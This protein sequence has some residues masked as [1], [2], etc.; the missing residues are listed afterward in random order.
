[1]I[2]QTLVTMTLA[3]LLA[4]CTSP[5]TESGPRPNV[6]IVVLDACRADK[7]SLYGF[8]RETTPNLSSLASDPDAVVFRRHYVQAPW[9]KPSTASLFTGRYVSQHKVYRG[10]GPRDNKTAQGAYVTDRLQDFQDVMAER[11]QRAGYRTFAVVWGGQVLPEYG[12]GQGFDQFFTDDVRGRV[13]QVRKILEVLDG[14]EQPAFGYAHFEGCHLPYEAPALDSSYMEQ[15]AVSYDREKRV[16]EGVDFS[17][18]SLVFD[19]NQH[20]KT[21]DPA[22]VAFL[23]LMYEARMKHEDRVVVQRLV[24]GLRAGGHWDDTLLVITAD[25]GEELYD[26]Q[27][28]GHGHGL[29]DAILHV[30]LVVKFPKGRRPAALGE[31]VDYV[32][33]AIDLLPSLGE[34]LGLPAGA[35]VAG[36]PIFGGKGPAQAIAERMPVWGARGYAVIRDEFKLLHHGDTQVLSR[37][38][39]DPGERTNLLAENPEVAKEMSDLVASLHQEA[40]RSDDAALVHIDLDPAAVEKLRRLGYIE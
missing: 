2:R 37:I 32:T 25:H 16:A 21:L 4:S 20:G 23:N 5:I 29:W 15:H 12:F 33:Q 31:D 3:L 27:G 10:H 22:D 8:P 6:L 36:T 30:P 11:F 17:K 1:M 28:Y 18:G 9:T 38:V 34:Y 7:M 39:A 40:F 13:G 19:I 35:A 26:H 14:S 24:A